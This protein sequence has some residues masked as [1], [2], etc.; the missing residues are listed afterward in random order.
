MPGPPPQWRGWQWVSAGLFCFC[1]RSLSLYT[2]SFDT[3]VC[4]SLSPFPESSVLVVVCVCVFTL[5]NLAF[6]LWQGLIFFF[7]LTR[8]H[9]P[10]TADAPAT[11]DPNILRLQDMKE[12]QEA[13]KK[14]LYIYIHIYIC[15]CVCVCVCMYI[16]IYIYTYIHT[17]IY[18]YIYVYMYRQDRRSAGRKRGQLATLA[19]PIQRPARPLSPVCFVFCFVS[20]FFIFFFGY[21]NDLFHRFV[22]ICVCVYSI[23]MVKWYMGSQLWPHRWVRHF[24][25][26]QSVL[27]V[28]MYMY[29]D[30]MIQWY[31][32]IYV[33]MVYI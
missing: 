13:R 11:A 5:R 24:R 6:C 26:H 16:Y 28:Y 7:C 2:L 25:F 15:M 20:V 1:I 3:Y 18:I 9:F 12:A 4:T 21:R 33:Y 22:F 8:S 23:H 19:A 17:Y 30:T 29:T 14:K 31:T 27:L 10:V 32:C